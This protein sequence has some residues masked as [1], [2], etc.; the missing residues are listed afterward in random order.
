[1]FDNISIEVPQQYKETLLSIKGTDED[2]KSLQEKLSSGN[3]EVLKA[4]H[5]KKLLFKI[6]NVLCKK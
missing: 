3:K 1:M 4:Y 5:S 2:L 6:D